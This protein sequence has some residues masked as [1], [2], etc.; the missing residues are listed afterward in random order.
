MSSYNKVN[1]MATTTASAVSPS[2]PYLSENGNR[3][4]YLPESDGKPMAETD[5]HR[6]YMLDLLDALEDYYRDDERTYVTGNIFVYYP[7]ETGKLQPVSPDIFVVRGVEKKDRRIYNIK[8]EGKAPDAVLEL[9][10]I[11]TKM[12][13]L[14][15]KKFLYASL[16]VKEYF[17]FD[18]IGDTMRPFLRGFRL[19]NNDYLPIVGTRLYSEVMG[20]ELRLEEGELRLYNPQTSTYLL[21]RREVHAAR[22]SAEAA[23]RKAEAA[24]QKAEEGRQKAEEGQQKAE[25]AQQ[26]AETAKKKA[27]V[28]AAQEAAARQAAEA[29]LAALRRELEMA[30]RGGKPT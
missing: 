13:D 1:V 23:Q 28:R 27:E 17:L 22:R 24:R 11:S 12:E 14:G 2:E 6:R 7:D 26:A 9:T 18:P 29:E 19:E 5:T 21:T 30:K 20:L 15:N 3:E 4:E 25:E 16:G 8:A 10:S